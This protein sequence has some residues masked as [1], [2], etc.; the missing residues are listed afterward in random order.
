M[1]RTGLPSESHP[2]HASSRPSRLWPAT[3]L[4]LLG[5]LPA[6]L[7]ADAVTQV[8]KPYTAELKAS[9]KGLPF[10]G[11][12]SRALKQN[13]DGSWELLFDARS[14]LLGISE[15]SRF[16]L[17]DG[18]IKPDAYNYRRSQLIGRQQEDQALFDWQL[19]QVNWSSGDDRRVI[20]L[21]KGV[22]DK[23]S[24]QTQLRMDLAAGKQELNY[25]IADEDELYQR[26]FTV[27]GE[28]VLTTEAGRFNTVK[29]KVRRDNDARETWIWFARDWDFFFVKLLQKE[30]RSEYTVEL[31]S[32]RIDGQ[33]INGL[34]EPP[35]PQVQ[36]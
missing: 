13:A 11:S 5:L 4:G 25:L 22:L 35:P 10:T 3:L 36:P 30:G 24:Y 8:L 9:I 1:T 16:Q 2:A 19:S 27:E 23:L 17:Q 33:L 12:G 29:V 21:Q 31:K 34:Q 14:S 26:R 15:S 7:Q 18:T 28:E 32:A 6:T 20:P